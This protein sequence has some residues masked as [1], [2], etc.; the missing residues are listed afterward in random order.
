MAN[1]EKDIASPNRKDQIMDAAA[2]LFAVN[3]FYKTTTAMVA[4][5]VGVTQ[6]YVFHFFKTKENL[7]L[8]VLERAQRRLIE[9]FVSV[10]APAEA[11]AHSMGDAF[12]GLMR[13]HRDETLICM[14]AHAVPEP[15]I[16]TEVRRM[17]LE[18]HEVVA[19]CFAQG[20]L[21]DPQRQ[22][23]WF[24]SCGLIISLSEILEAPELGRI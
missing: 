6:P 3:G 16:R 18:V 9:A 24:I 4:A 15:N 2:S 14:Q 17:F 10:Q 22:A 23:S 7:Y 5:E 13:T 21:P 19:R 12:N 1:K 20:G 11:L 8:A